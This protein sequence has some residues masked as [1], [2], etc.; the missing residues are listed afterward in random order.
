MTKQLQ[1][2]L[3]FLDELAGFMEEKAK[4]SDEVQSPRDVI[5]AG[6]ESAGTASTFIFNTVASEEVIAQGFVLN[7]FFDTMMENREMLESNPNLFMQTVANRAKEAVLAHKTML[8]NADK[9]HT[10]YAQV[11]EYAGEGR[12]H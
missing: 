12:P 1:A 7:A 8:E 4:G 2:T 9:Y 5:E 10:Y 6:Q 3:K 11:E